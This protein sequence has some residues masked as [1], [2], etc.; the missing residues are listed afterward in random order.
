VQAG[1]T[2][3]SSDLVVVGYNA[4]PNP[5]TFALMALADI[6]S[7][8]VV[9]LTDKGIFD[10]SGNFTSHTTQDG[11]VKWTTAAISKGTIIRFSNTFNTT[12]P[13]AL[14][15]SS[16]GSIAHVTSSGTFFIG[17]NGDQIL[18][19]QTSDDSFTGSSTNTSNI[20]RLSA[21]GVA[22]SGF[23]YAF[24]ADRDEG[25]ADSYSDSN[26]WWT[27]AGSS[28]TSASANDETRLPLNSTAVNSSD[29][30]GNAGT[31]NAF[32][33]LSP[34]RD[35]WVY[36]GD[37]NAATKTQWLTRIHTVA[38]WT[39]SDSASVGLPTGNFT[40][41][42]DPATV[43][44][45]NASSNAYYNA[46]DT[47]SV[48]VTF[49]KAVA[50]SGTP[51]LQ[52]NSGAS[53]YANYAS[54]G[55]SDTLVFTYTVSAG[56]TSSDLD[57]SST[58]ALTLNGGTITSGGTPATLTLPEPGAAGSLGANRNIVIDTTAPTISISAPSRTVTASSS[59]TYTITYTG[60]DSVTLANNHILLQSTSTANGT[61]NV[62]GTGTSERTVTISGITGNGSLGISIEPGTAGDLAGNL[63]PE[64]GASTTFTVDNT[65]PTVSISEP[66]ASS[67]SGADVTYT[68]TYSGANTVT[69][70]NGDVTLNSTGTAT[71]TV[72][73]T[74]SGST[75]R[76][77]TISSIAGNG[78]LGVSLASGTA[79][80]LASNPAGAAGPSSTF[81]VLGGPSVTTLSATNVTM[82]GATLLALV[83]PNGRVTAAVFESG[84][85]TAYGTVSPV[86]LSPADG[87]LE[88]LVSVNLAGLTPSTTYHFR[89]G[90]TNDGG[91]AHGPDLTFTTASN[92]LAPTDVTLGTNSVPENLPPGTAVGVFTAI[93]PDEGDTATYALISGTG[94]ED[95]TSFQI[96]GATLETAAA[97]DYETRSTYSIR[98]SVTDLGGLSF[99]KVFVITVDD[100]NEAPI[101][102]GYTLTAARNTPVTVHVAKVLARTTDPEGDSRFMANADAASA[103]GGTVQ[104]SGSTI[105]YSPPADYSG[106]DS[107]Q[108]GISDGAITTTGLV[109]VTV[110]DAAGNGLTLLS[111]VPTGDNVRL[112]FTGIAGR[113]YLIQHTS[114]LDAAATWTTLDTVTAD[115]GGFFG[116]THVTPPSPSYWRA[117]LTTAP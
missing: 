27:G 115:I 45:V 51:R 24:N 117:I 14:T 31:A 19:F 74:G 101:F 58:S 94:D 40:V 13:V 34:E 66:S 52:L 104:L 11:I 9:F 96:N 33:R 62:S 76:T 69:L 8:T 97:F 21:A 88:Q 48:N 116:H 46:G 82:S 81:T 12:A 17:Q 47:V 1:P 7:G 85:N 36:S 86:V 3:K 38:N 65:P 111:I 6:P 61:V 110:G 28:T 50:V 35:N 20:Q 75:T 79:S 32:G 57:Y 83:N 92:T 93:D 72:N 112:T 67:T 60:A 107:F 80:D 56:D 54:G 44:S 5:R 108:I 25:V 70:S 95:N 22:E 10:T 26:G 37:T 43:S 89:I 73:V 106:G 109:T 30:T 105:T 53:V 49:S 84:T 29:G 113:H 114:T 42:A 41:V 16:H 102:S 15:D 63:A 98:L 100:I 23:I 103:H 90:A 99:E 77:V 87:S 68:I 2:L 55:G 91:Y 39:S 71:G 64:S 4:D 59:V 18:I 78:S